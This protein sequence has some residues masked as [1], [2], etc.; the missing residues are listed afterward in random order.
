M[1]RSCKLKLFV[2]FEFSIPETLKYIISECATLFIC[3]H[4]RNLRNYCILL[5]EQL[6]SLI[7][8]THNQSENDE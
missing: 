6:F 4:R 5:H 7:I 1:T 2:Q 3:S 8:M